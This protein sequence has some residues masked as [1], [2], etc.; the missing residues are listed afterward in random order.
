MRLQVVSVCFVFLLDI[1][2]FKRLKRNILE[3]FLLTLIS[4]SVMEAIT[5]NFLLHAKVQFFSFRPGMSFFGKVG[6]K[7]QNCQ[8]KLK[9]G[10]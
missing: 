2:R 4:A 9:F 10:T 8:F 7:N 6:P 1:Q 3:T 5:R